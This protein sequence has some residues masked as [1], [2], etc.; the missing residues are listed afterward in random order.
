MNEY[1]YRL[2]P[3]NGPGTRYKCPKCGKMRVFSRYIDQDS[4][5]QLADHV[6]RCDREVNCGYHFTP[7]QY[8]QNLGPLDWSHASPMPGS[9]TVAQR[10]KIPS[11][12]PIETL[13]ASLKGYEGN[14]FVQYLMGLYGASITEQI[15]SR[16][17]IG[18]SKHWPGATLFWQIDL[19]GKA[20]TG[21]IMAYDPVT[22][23]RV[24]DRIT[25]VHK[26]LNFPDFNLDQCLFGEHLLKT[27]HNKPVS[28][29]ESEKTAIIAS[30]YLPQFIWLA[31]GG[32]SNISAQKYQVL[33]GLHVVLWP[34]LNCFEKWSEKAKELFCICRSIKVSDLLE[35]NATPADREQGLDLADYLVRYDYRDFAS[36]PQQLPSLSSKD[37]QYGIAKTYLPKEYGNCILLAV[38]MRDG[39]AYD[40]LLQ[41]NE[42][43]FQPDTNPEI[44]IKIER[45]FNK[46]FQ[47]MNLDETPYLIH[48][49]N[50][51]KK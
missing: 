35:R 41:G 14:H 43:I 42:E 31:S 2:E 28:L 36:P 15:I 38:K 44:L 33:R 50:C 21:K 30:V 24:K 6:G 10:A 11:Y 13:K 17:Y 12:I 3:Y 47:H 48:S 49:I 34:D 20:R 46:H 19:R 23:H 27:D 8:F 32:L 39:K 9:R 40:I 22:G 5:N 25:W 37:I 26:L 7:K 18:T 16:Y 29:V 51:P 4:G 45:D 1:R